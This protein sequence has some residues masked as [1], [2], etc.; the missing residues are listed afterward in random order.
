M[1][2]IC[3]CQ[4][5]HLSQIDEKTLAKSIQAY[6][7]LIASLEAGYQM[8]F[9]ENLCSS[10]H[11]LPWQINS[12]EESLSLIYNERGQLR[13]LIVNFNG[14]IR[15]YTKAI[16]LMPNAV[17]FY[18]RGQVYYRLGKNIFLIRRM[19]RQDLS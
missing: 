13:Y 5:A 11:K 3:K 16:E 15:D 8:T 4:I 14:A 18:N 19:H 1:A 7:E 17:S 12:R 2:L 10:C 9:N 6:T